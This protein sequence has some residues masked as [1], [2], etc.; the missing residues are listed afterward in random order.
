MARPLLLSVEHVVPHTDADGLAAG[1][2]ALRARGEGAAA[3]VLLGRGKTPF[4]P[5][6]PLP[7]GSVAVLDWGIRP[8]A[9]P[10]L[11]VDHHVPEA[12][13]AAGQ[14][15]ISGHGEDPETTTAALMRRLVP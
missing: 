5:E 10:G 6:A 7:G 14:I 2:I 3:A 1:A 11:F 9:R 8:L 12:E 4:G 15:A 13:P